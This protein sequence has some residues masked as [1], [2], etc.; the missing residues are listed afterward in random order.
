MRAFYSTKASTLVLSD[1]DE[2]LSNLKLNS[3]FS[4][5]IDSGTFFFPYASPIITSANLDCAKI[6]GP[7][8]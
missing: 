8:P 6:S 3:L 7:N 4:L 5:S 2:S 1:F